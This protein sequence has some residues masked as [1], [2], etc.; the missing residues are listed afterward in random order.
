MTAPPAPPFQCTLSGDFLHVTGITRQPI[1]LWSVS[2]RVRAAANN[3]SAALT[4]PTERTPVFLGIEH[5]PALQ[6]MWPHTRRAIVI[7]KTGAWQDLFGRQSSIMLQQPSSITLCRGGWG[8]CSPLHFPTFHTQWYQQELAHLALQVLR[9]A[10]AA[11]SHI[12]IFGL[13]EHAFETTY[14]HYLHRA[15]HTV[16]AAVRFHNDTVITY[17][18]ETAPRSRRIGFL[19]LVQDPHDADPFTPLFPPDTLSRWKMDEIFS[20]TDAFVSGVTPCTSADRDPQRVDRACEPFRQ[21]TR[22][23]V[24]CAK[25]ERWQ[26]VASRNLAPFF[27]LEAVLFQREALRR[28]KLTHYAFFRD[29]FSQQNH[30]FQGGWSYPCLTTFFGDGQTIF[31]Q[32]AT[33][34]A[35]MYAPAQVPTYFYP[36]HYVN[37]QQPLAPPV[38]LRGQLE[39]DIA[40]VHNTRYYAVTYNE[41]NELY[42]LVTSI[43]PRGYAAIGPLLWHLRHHLQVQQPGDPSAAYWSQT[44]NKIEWLFYAQMRIRWVMS[45]LPTL[46]RYR[47]TVFGADWG[48]LLPAQL[49]GSLITREQTA[50][51]FRTSAIT[52]DCTPVDTIRLP[53]PTAVECIAA[54]GF[55]LVVAPVYGDP[56]ERSVGCFTADTLVYFRTASELQTLVEHY[57]T[58]WNARQEFIQHAQA[59]WLKTLHAGAYHIPFAQLAHDPITRALPVAPS[60]TDSPTVDD[61][62]TRVAV[63]YAYSLAGF[64]GS[65]LDCWEKCLRDPPVPCTALAIRA[66]KCAEE[67]SLCP[68]VPMS[69]HHNKSVTILCKT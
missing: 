35:T 42:E 67:L 9:A 58:D 30:I 41:F 8:F 11:L 60:I 7:E 28:C 56:G 32:H 40:I 18:D 46:M 62:I 24:A 6:K 2:E 5:L 59:G 25:R 10:E 66:A 64:V 20:G 65:A 4:L 50:H 26:A 69:L 22:A 51:I 61:W 13:P 21:A 17:A 63:G 57:L 47:T 44:V 39:R 3:V 16:S 49:C 29:T 52:I 36:Y 37:A 55:P 53:H 34:N 68:Y 1:A 43:S 19:H 48:R 23:L 45:L 33:Q 15:L 38:A 12:T 31:F 14:L 54:G 27:S